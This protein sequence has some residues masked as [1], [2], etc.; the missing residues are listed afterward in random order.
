[1]ETTPKMDVQRQVWHK[2]SVQRLMI[3]VDTRQ[4]PGSVTDLD[5][6]DLIFQDS[7]GPIQ[8]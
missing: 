4:G 1:M 3:A 5:G 6:F 2:P 8:V 7:E